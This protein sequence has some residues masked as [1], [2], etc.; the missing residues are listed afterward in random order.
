M[1][2]DLKPANIKLTPEGKVKVLD[3]GLAKAWALDPVSGGSSDLSRS[4]TMAYSGTH[5]GVILGTAAYMSPEQARGKTV[6]RRADIWA[7][8][9][10]LYEMLVGG[11]L[12]GGETV[13]DVIAS[14]VKE[15]PDW[16]KLPAD[17]PRVL[18]SLLR[19]CLVK[20]P[21]QRLRDIGDARLEIEQAL[22]GREEAPEAG[23]PPAGAVEPTSRWRRIAPWVL[24]AVLG[25]GGAALGVFLVLGR[26]PETPVVRFDIVPPEGVRLALT[27][28]SPGP[29]RVSPDGRMLAYTAFAGAGGQR[30]F[31]RALDEADP[32]A[33]PGT[34][35]AQYPFWSPDSRQIGF[36]ADRKLKRVEAAGG[37]P[38]SLCEAEDGK[39]GS[40]GSE[41][42]IV[43]A[44]S[45]DQ[46]IHRVPETGGEA[47][48]VTVFDKTR[49]DDSHRHPR[50]LPDGRHLIYLAR[51]PDGAQ[52]G[53]A[54]V[55][56]S[57][58]GGEGKVLLHSPAAVEYAGG[59]LFFL[60]DRTLMAQ[61]FDPDRLEL[62]GEARPI[63]DP[64]TF[65]ATGTA[66]AV[67]SASSG[68]VLAWQSGEAGQ[69][70][71][72]LVWRD[73]AGTETGTA[74][75]PADFGVVMLS[76][77]GDYAAASLY[78]ERSGRQ[79]LWVYEVARGL[80]SRFT[81]DDAE[82]GAP[83]WSPEGD[84]IAF[85]SNRSGTFDIYV[86]S[87]GG[88]SEET[89]LYASDAEKSPSGWHPDGDVLAFDQRG[90]ETGW[91]IWT[92]NLTGEPQAQPFLQTPFLEYGAAFS[93]DGRWV[94]YGSN[95]SGEFQVYVRAW[96]GPG[97][98]WQ[99]STAPASWPRWSRGGKEI[100]YEAMDGALLAAPV[101]V[102]GESLVVGT[103]VELF[104]GP[105]PSTA[106][107]FDLSSDGQRVLLFEP[108]EKPK[109]AP[110]LS[111][112]VNWPAT[113]ERR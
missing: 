37:P 4:P 47:K 27:S 87:V 16:E 64:V 2:R 41:G 74:G 68:G 69:R 91:D 94:L 48:P 19:R 75:E 82:D 7:F 34:E 25:L 3:F 38:L 13:T 28:T 112:L 1:H 52:E 14:V 88:A 23:P 80:G 55:V 60:R 11:A 30:L 100:V 59:H 85:S 56:G 103:P 61:P 97:R 84:R 57:I 105:G 53:Q 49:K 46:P 104:K 95:E 22:S 36:F 73:R 42:V 26:P 45:F 15:Q 39:G 20:D 109:A 50:F 102:R 79:D 108:V 86:K 96:P 62:Q 93:P 78:D 107:C 17:T 18:R 81:F 54:I 8:G 92:L 101:E 40:W 5:A 44:P 32:R 76:P 70:Q 6:D 89:L 10:V 9:V 58:D 21:R 111:V 35:G 113:L 99:V 65:L 90:E 106:N 67:F 83:V 98:Q 66:H 33:L 71:Q 51:Y 29:V 72:R 24:A 77:R 43:F 12:F 31:V 110:P 63:V